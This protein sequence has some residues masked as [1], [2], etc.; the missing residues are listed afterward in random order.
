[1][2]PDGDL[3]VRVSGEDIATSESGAVQIFYAKSGIGL[4]TT[5]DKLIKLE[6]F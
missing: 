5:W 4:N 2:G 6:D 3:A 1:M